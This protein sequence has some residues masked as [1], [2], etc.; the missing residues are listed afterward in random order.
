MFGFIRQKITGRTGHLPKT[1]I[2]K[3]VLYQVVLNE[4]GDRWRAHYNLRNAEH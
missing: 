4:T 1:N 2:Y 3:L